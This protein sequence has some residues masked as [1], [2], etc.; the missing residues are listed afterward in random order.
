MYNLSLPPKAKEKM[1]YDEKKFD[2]K[3]CVE[4][5]KKLKKVM[6]ELI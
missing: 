3:S 5:F 6:N 1:V 2:K 4:R